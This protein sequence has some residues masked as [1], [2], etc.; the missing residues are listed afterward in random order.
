MAWQH[1]L[2]AG[3]L[4]YTVVI[5]FANRIY[6]IIHLQ[7]FCVKLSS[8]ETSQGRQN[9]RDGIRNHSVFALGMGKTFDSDACPVN[10][11]IFPKQNLK[12]SRLSIVSQPLCLE[13][14]QSP[15]TKATCQTP[16]V[17]IPYAVR[18]IYPPKYVPSPLKETNSDREARRP[19]HRRKPNLQRPTDVPLRLRRQPDANLHRRDRNQRHGR[20]AKQNDHLVGFS[21]QRE[22][23][24]GMPS[25]TSSVAPE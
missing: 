8:S 3:L 5:A 2:R 1:L 14:W 20:R 19:V 25:T 22:I 11:L 16:G 4:R 9:A 17:S 12:I 21:F 10:I 6:S 24:G 15:T 7:Y 23:A 13:Q 18:L